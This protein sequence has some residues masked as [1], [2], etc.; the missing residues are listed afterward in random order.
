MVESKHYTIE[1][2]NYLEAAGL[3][4]CKQASIISES[5]RRPIKTLIINERR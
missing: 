4:M 3:I 1:V 2:D 5:V